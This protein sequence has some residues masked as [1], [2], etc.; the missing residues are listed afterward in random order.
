MKFRKKGWIPEMVNEQNRQLA[1][2]YCRNIPDSNED[3]RRELE[4]K[5]GKNVRFF[6]IPCSGRLEPLHLLKAL[7]EFADAAYIIAC[8]EGAC[9]YFE[10]N[11]RA[12][13]RLERTQ[14]IIESIGLEKERLDIIINSGKDPKGLD[15]I[16]GEIIERASSL[17]FSP[18][19]RR[20]TGTFAHDA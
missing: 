3:K 4:I 8:P 16:T 10:G 9:R 5:Y 6:P 18:V 19:H 13:K 2:F 11:L 12:L 7:E 20:M 14:S 1:I 17:P 15:R